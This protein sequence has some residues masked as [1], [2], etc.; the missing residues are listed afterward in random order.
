MAMERCI[1]VEERKDSNRKYP[2]MIAGH[3]AESS[4]NRNIT[5]NPQARV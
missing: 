5:A 2:K 3:E 1:N 4:R